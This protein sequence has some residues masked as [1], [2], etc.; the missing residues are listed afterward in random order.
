ME[1]K[2]QADQPIKK[3]DSAT[4]ATI[5]P[6]TIVFKPKHVTAAHARAGKQVIIKQATNHTNQ[7]GVIKKISSNNKPSDHKFTA[8]NNG[9]KSRGRNN[10]PAGRGGPSRREEALVSTLS[11]NTDK[12]VTT[13]PI[14][15]GVVNLIPLGSFGEIGKAVVAYEY[16]DSI[17]VVDCGIMFPTEEMLG[18]DSVIPDVRYL[19][20]NKEKIKGWFFTHGHEDHIGSVSYILPKFPNVQIYGGN[21]TIGMIRLK[22]EEVGHKDAK[23]AVIKPGDKIQAGPFN[24]EAIQIAHSIPDDLAFA[25]RTDQGLIVHLPDWKIDHTPLFGQITDLARFSELGMEGIDLLVAESTN[26]EVP[27]YTLSEQIV[28]ETFDRIFKNANGRIVIAMF[29]SLINRVQQIFNAAVK[30]KR[31]IAISGRSMEKNVQMALQLGYLK[32]PDGLLVDLRKVNTLANDEVVI[33]TTGAQ[34]EEYSALVRMANGEHRNIKIKE[35]DTVVISASPIPGNERNISETIDNLFKLG[36]TVLYGRGVDVHVSGHAQQEELKLMLSITKPKYFVP[37]HGEYR[38]LKL[39]AKMAVKMGANPNNCIIMENGEVVEF[40][41][42]KAKKVDTKVQAGAI[43]VDGIGVGDV[44]AIVL[45]D[46]QA[47]AKE[48]IFVLILTVNKQTGQLLSS[49]DIISRGFIYMRE[50]EDLV[51]EARQE[52]KKL[53]ARHSEKNPLQWDALKRLARDE[54]SRFLFEKTQRQPIVIPVVIEV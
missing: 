43:L 40:E 10:G 38:M 2:N 13:K 28:G 11:S 32:A 4:G 12:P 15:K 31:K 21:L 54:V 23:L 27:G 34:G 7:P 46:R 53:F 18:V 25:I 50:R 14:R 1:D 41:E 24:I 45:R 17:I 52:I 9:T 36:A 49:P 44:G 8:H 20:E 33:L 37:M 6:N 26:I 42:H 22:L 30:H 3:V 39:H 47:M 19:E 48:G 35:N 51:Y 29:S 5:S 16:Q